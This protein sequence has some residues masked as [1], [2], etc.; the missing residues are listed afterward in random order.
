MTTALLDRRAV[1]ATPA[2]SCIRSGTRGRF[3]NV[4]D[5]VLD[6]HE[7][8]ADKLRNM[9]GLTD[10]GATLVD[11]ALAGELPLIATRKARSP[12]KKDSPIS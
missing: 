7:R 5:L 9:T 10:D 12:N 6:R 8:V 2:R 11:G 1:S 4:V 3:Y